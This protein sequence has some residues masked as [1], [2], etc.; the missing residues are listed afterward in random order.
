ML[1][2]LTWGPSWVSAHCALLDTLQLLY[3]SVW[4]PLRSLWVC[5]VRC[6]SY[7]SILRPSSYYLHSVHCLTRRA[8]VMLHVI[9]CGPPQQLPSLL[10]ASVLA[11]VTHMRPNVSPDSCINTSSI[12]IRTAF[13][14]P[15]QINT[16]YP[17]KRFIAGHSYLNLHMLAAILGN[18]N[19]NPQVNRGLHLHHH[20]QWRGVVVLHNSIYSPRHGE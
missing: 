18:L 4:Y 6:M 15:S 1:R 16:H 17:I 12:N 11:A 2:V 20:V 19:H 5:G 14:R 8:V 3:L 7:W 9:T 13:A 10:P